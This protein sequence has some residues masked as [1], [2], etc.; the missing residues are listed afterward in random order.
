L[1]RTHFATCKELL[2]A[3]PAKDLNQLRNTTRPTG[4]MTGSKAG[5]IVS[6]VFIE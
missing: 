5:A 4:L 1:E 2:R 3:D 6:E